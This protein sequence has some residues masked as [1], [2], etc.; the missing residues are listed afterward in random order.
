MGSAATPWS[1]TWTGPSVLSFSNKHGAT[2][3]TV[4]GIHSNSADTPTDLAFEPRVHPPGTDYATILAELEAHLAEAP[5]SRTG[6][7]VGR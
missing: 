4:T 5:Q 2:R 1:F 6:A 3:I 7:T